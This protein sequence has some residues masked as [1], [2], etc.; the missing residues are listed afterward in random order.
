MLILAAQTLAEQTSIDPRDIIAILGFILGG[1]GIWGIFKWRQER[2]LASSNAHAGLIVANT[3]QWERL[4][5]GVNQRVE[6]LEVEIKEVRSL[7][8]Y[9]REIK[10]KDDEHEFALTQHIYRGDPPPPP[11]KAPVQ[12]FDAWRTRKEED[13]S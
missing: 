3:E 10:H 11:K 1:S 4:L 13:Q 5:K 6:D 9:L 2:K 12:H 7:V 8:D